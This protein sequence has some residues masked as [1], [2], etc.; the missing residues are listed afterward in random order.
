MSDRCIISVILAVNKDQGFL[1]D[2]IRSILNQSFEDFELLIIANNCSDELWLWIKN[3]ALSDNRIRIFR[4]SLGGL[5]F[6]LNYGLNESKGKYIARMDADDISLTNRF[7]VQY[8]YLESNPNIS[9]VGSLVKFIG[10]D[11]ESLNINSQLPATHEDIVKYSKINSPLMHPS[12]MG[13]RSFFLELGGY[14]YG[15]YGEDYELWLR[16][17]LSGYKYYNIQQELLKYR[18][19]DNQLSSSGFDRKQSIDVKG[20]LSRYLDLE[21]NLKYRWG[22]FRQ[23]RIYFRLIKLKAQLMSICK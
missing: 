19:H 6:A 16:G 7:Q 11:G 9:V 21:P 18:L 3:L 22:I 17:I 23:T 2:S 14:K 13:K 15:F 5:T 4:L 12:I 20:I 1:E 8:D 10:V